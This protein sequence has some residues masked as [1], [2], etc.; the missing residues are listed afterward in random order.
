M[1]YLLLLLLLSCSNKDHLIYNGR[2]VAV[3]KIVKT[4]RGITVGYRADV[5]YIKGI[6]KDVRIS[7]PYP[8]GSNIRL[9]CD[10]SFIIQ[11]CYGLLNNKESGK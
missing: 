10:D 4:Y 2:V 1:R 6:K 9:F 7:R 11:T 8:V 3:Y 5:S